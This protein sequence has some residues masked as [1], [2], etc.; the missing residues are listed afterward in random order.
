MVIRLKQDFSIWTH[1][2]TQTFVGPSIHFC[3]QA[4]Q[5]ISAH[6]ELYSCMSPKLLVTSPSPLFGQATVLH[7]ISVPGSF[8]VTISIPVRF[9]AA[10]LKGDFGRYGDPGV[11]V[12][13]CFQY[14]RNRWMTEILILFK[15][16]EP[17]PIRE[18]DDYTYYV[19]LQC[20]SLVKT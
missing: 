5:L 8:K 7:Q 16:I 2:E 14:W 10:G 4:I 1:N 20:E 17:T 11:F 12:I 6:S 13:L 9:G 3:F 15:E 18:T 19:C